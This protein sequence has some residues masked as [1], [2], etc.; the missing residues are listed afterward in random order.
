MAIL[1]YE[2]LIYYT[3]N[4]L[5]FS[6]F[7][8]YQGCSGEGPRAMGSMWSVQDQQA[9]VFLKKRETSWLRVMLHYTFAIMFD[10]VLFRNKTIVCKNTMHV[11]D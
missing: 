5:I 6:R 9:S 11:Q 10:A 4:A 2:I 3:V 7:E 1:D 8:S